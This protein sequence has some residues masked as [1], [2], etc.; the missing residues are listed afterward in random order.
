MTGPRSGW[1]RL[2]TLG[3]LAAGGCILTTSPDW[4]VTSGFIG[5]SGIPVEV[6]S[7]PDTVA[8][9][10]SFIVVVTTFGSRTCTRPAGADV[11][12]SGLIASVLP[13]DSIPRRGDTV[14][15]RDLSSFPRNVSLTF[16]TAGQ[17]V[18]SVTGRGDHGDTTIGRPIAVR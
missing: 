1:K 11:T 18:I 7:S 14:C 13:L 16:G 9:G 8:A 3:F 6:I 17:G 5:V 4:V 15:T 10:V 2:G 12:V